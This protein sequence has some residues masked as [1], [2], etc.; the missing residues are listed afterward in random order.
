M[1]LMSTPTQ[2][3]GTLKPMATVQSPPPTANDSQAW[4]L[5]RT[6]TLGCT[7]KWDAKP[8]PANAA[9]TQTADSH[10]AATATEIE[11]DQRTVS[12]LIAGRYR[13][14][15]PIGRGGFGR[16]WR[17]TDRFT[18]EPVA[19]K[20]C[21]ALDDARATLIRDEVTALQWAGLPG[22]V[23]LRDDGFEGTTAFLVMDLVEGTPFPGRT[24]VPLTEITARL[25]EVI[26]RLHGIGVF[27][28]DIKPDNVLVDAAGYPT[29]LDLGIARGRALRVGDAPCDYV[30]H[31]YAAPE[32]LSLGR[33]DA[34]SDLYSIGLM[35]D[36]ASA[37]SIT[38]GTAPGTTPGS[39]LDRAHD[40]ALD[41]TLDT[42]LARL[43]LLLTRNDPDRRPPSAAAALALLGDTTRLDAAPKLAE[44]P[45]PAALEA[46]FI[47]PEAFLHH[48][49][50]A[51]RVL[52]TRTGGRP[53][54]MRRELS[55][56]LR[57]GFAW[58][59]GDAIALRAEGLA[60]LVDGFP[61]AVDH[62]LPPLPRAASDLLCWI[63]LALP[64]TAITR[65]RAVVPMTPDDF[66]A[67]LAALHDAG[68]IWVLPNDTRPNDTRP[69]ATR[70]D[71]TPLDHT[72]PDATLGTWV[73]PDPAPGWPL[74]RLQQAHAALGAS[75]PPDS[76]AAVR[77]AIAADYTAPGLTDRIATVARHLVLD[78]RLREAQALLAVGLDLARARG[79]AEDEAQLLP[80]SVMLALTGDGADAI[81]QTR[82][83]I[84]RALQR[85]PHI[86][87]LERLLRA[88]KAT[89]PERSRA[90]LAA[91]GPLADRHLERLWHMLTVIHARREGIDAEAQALAT[92][93]DW[94]EQDPANRRGEYLCWLG[95]LRY[96]QGRYHEAADLH[97]EAARIC[98][99]HA[100]AM[101]SR[102]NEAAAWLE[103]FEMQRAIDRAREVRAQARALRHP[104]VELRTVFIERIARYR[105]GSAGHPRPA[106]VDS[107]ARLGTAAEAMIAGVEAAI[108]WRFG[109]PGLARTFGLRAARRFEEEGHG[110]VAALY[111]ALALRCG[112]PFDPDEICALVALAENC[113]EADFGLQI[114]GLI[115]FMLP[116]GSLSDAAL[117]LA[118]RGRPVSAWHHRLDVLSY[119]EAL[120]LTGVPS[121]A[122]MHGEKT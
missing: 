60:R 39:A 2:R 28:G 42:A 34:R 120:N 32:Q 22:V 99:G 122:P 74:E 93:A 87:Q 1:P 121:D 106:M 76:A 107:A 96:R 68:A 7:P 109:H 40:R 62:P 13:L 46:L 82:Y 12:A 119:R 94:S 64:L 16:V 49:S 23:R 66:D 65:L 56:W 108:A 9:R 63:R 116:S 30:T 14:E 48:R 110:E 57:A 8:P 91:V 85:T 111:Q 38:H 97:C 33:V 25:L 52:W 3:D 41:R 104:Q 79:H 19:V 112:A 89:T 21:P 24:H 71:D 103:A 29:V 53:P 17:A 114:M 70:P 26:A 86:E 84:G 100:R 88:A 72:R 101:A 105:L 18:G 4:A 90:L 35:V 36:E 5:I 59:E 44:A 10:P 69:D 54:A 102:I 78:G 61:V 50:E 47:G 80:V 83:L 37:A 81:R 115:A 118:A 75:L 11:V 92:A 45:T 27:H 113:R 20:L 6:A 55:A 67:A 117:R 77:H 51:A 43:V 95:E 15:A 58:R 98:V 73:M 31:R